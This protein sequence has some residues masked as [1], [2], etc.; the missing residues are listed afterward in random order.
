MLVLVLINVDVPP[1]ELEPRKITIHPNCLCNYIP[2]G[3]RW[4]KGTKDKSIEDLDKNGGWFGRLLLKE[5]LD[6]IRNMKAS[7]GKWPLLSAVKG[8]SNCS[9]VLKNAFKSIE[10]IQP[11]IVGFEIA[12]CCWCY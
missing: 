7:S 9:D 2:C 11:G 4:G 12:V 3:V 10:R 5:D 1:E 8:N 6:M